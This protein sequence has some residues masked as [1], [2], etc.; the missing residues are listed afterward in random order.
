MLLV[1]TAVSVNFG[2]AQTNEF[3]YQGKLNDGTMA[4]NGNYD[5]QFE[6]HNSLSSTTP[7]ASATLT[8]VTVANGI[9]TVKLNFAATL[10]DGTNRFLKISVKPAGNPNPF[11]SLAPYQPITSA[12]YAI[13]SLNA[14]NALN[15]T[16][17]DLAADSSRLGGIT[18]DQYVQTNDARMSDARTPLP[19]SP[20]YVQN[21]TSPQSSSNFNV[22]GTGTANVFNAA[23]QYNIGGNR[24]FIAQGGS[25]QNV[26]GG[27]NAG[28]SNS[29]GFGNTFVGNFAGNANTT[30]NN[31]SF[32]GADAGRSAT[33]GGNS[34]FGRSA[35]FDTTNG[36][37]NAFFGLDAGR[38]NITG[39]NNAFFGKESG[40]NNTAD[41]NSF[42][43][44]RAGFGN[45]SG[46]SNASFGN[47][48]GQ[49]NQT[50]NFNS[51]FG[52]SAGVANT[53]GGN[54]SFFG[55]ASG[56]SNTGGSFNTF[57]GSGAGL[58]NTT[59]GNNTAI[60][61]LANFGSNNLNYATAVGSGST[62]STSNTIALG[63]S[64]GSD[65]VLIYGN[66]A[67][68]GTFN[69]PA[70]D[71]DYIQNRTTQQSLSNFNIS[72]SGTANIF[73]AATQYNING[74][75]V[76]SVN[77]TNNLF[78]GSTNLSSGSGNTFIGAGAGNAAST[79]NNNTFIGNGAGSGSTTGSSNVIIGNNSNTG[80]NA[81]NTII[82]GNNIG[83]ILSDAVIIGTNTNSVHIDG[84]VRVGSLNLLSYG[85][86]ATAI[87]RNGAG[88]IS[89]CSSS[90]RYKT[91]IQTFNGGLNLLRRFR[92][93]TFDWKADGNNDIGFVAEEVNEIEPLL[94][95]RNSSGEI[96]GVKYAQI[97]TVL[98]NAVNEQQKII[99]QQ[100]KQ[101]D[102]L[103]QLVCVQNP[104][105]EICKK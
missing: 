7:L 100:Q 45:T 63:R 69:I 4:A 73:N 21:T 31:N 55:S 90:R 25:L 51:F 9:F 35:G 39:S 19:G 32:F 101:I 48:A 99:E 6:L 88:D 72:G 61:Y 57:Y 40:F 11:T 86:G 89:N 104:N 59:G 38:F 44:Y 87:C 41:G 52:S 26:F 12:P 30:T 22:S 14:Q 74:N 20:N 75:R 58:A 62:V 60:G 13:K 84:D 28:T 53:S 36:T 33:G 3:T 81:V 1:L 83:S 82:I 79:G 70:G 66:F 18:A 46:N 2:F 80:S 76:L 5:F 94:T 67:V 24:V 68:N 102:A 54:N 43:G 37:N 97:T 96:E 91:N 23:T 98:V 47:G 65:S 29:T 85:S 16:T 103:K 95:T 34:F 78:V 56:F 49:N 50:G 17:A 8:G 71:A 93:V 64:D 92:P 105:A 27:L 42:F 77:G 10:F 15:S